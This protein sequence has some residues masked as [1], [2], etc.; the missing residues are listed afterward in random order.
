MKPY[1]P[2]LL[3]LLTLLNHPL[4]GVLF[5]NLETLREQYKVPGV[6]IAIVEKDQE[7][8]WIF[9]GWAD[10]ERKISLTPQTLF[11]VGSISKVLS[12]WGVQYLLEE[13]HQDVDTPIISYLTPQ[14]S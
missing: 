4:F 1:I 5:K 12:A 8:L 10:R 11:Q 6:A 13:I 7:P 2:F 9:S 14:S 3:T